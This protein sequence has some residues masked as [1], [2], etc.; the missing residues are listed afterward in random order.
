MSVRVFGS[1]RC[2]H[3]MH[4]KEDL[5]QRH[6]PFTFT[7]CDTDRQLCTD[8][9][10][11]AIPKLVGP[12]GSDVV[13]WGRDA[14]SISQTLCKLGVG[15]CGAPPPARQEQAPGMRYARDQ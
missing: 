3:C 13:G 5:A 7:N 12:N 4:A 2:P 6:I 10:V 1:E 14:G 8:N 15:P 9:K 11:S